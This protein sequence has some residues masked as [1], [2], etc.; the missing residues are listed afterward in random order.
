MPRFFCRRP[1]CRRPRPGLARARMRRVVQSSS[2]SEE[3]P[4]GKASTRLRHVN[5]EIID[6][7]DSDGEVEDVLF[8]GRE[9]LPPLQPFDEQHDQ[10]E[11]DDDGLL[12]L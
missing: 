7:S 3:L 12:V 6:I 1:H 8:G 5:P 4:L 11:T 9:P 10:T 2:S